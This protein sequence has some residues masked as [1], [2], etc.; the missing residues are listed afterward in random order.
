MNTYTFNGTEVVILYTDEVTNAQPIYTDGDKG[1]YRC[2]DV[3][4][5]IGLLTEEDDYSGYSGNCEIVCTEC[6]NPE[7]EQHLLCGFWSKEYA[8]Q[9]R[10]IRELC[11]LTDGHYGWTSERESMEG[12]ISS[13]AEDGE[14]SEEAAHRLR[15]DWEETV[16]A[17]SPSAADIAMKVPTF[18]E[19]LES[20]GVR[21]TDKLEAFARD[22]DFLLFRDPREA[23]AKVLFLPSMSAVKLSEA[24]GVPT[25]S[26]SRF[27]NGKDGLTYDNLCKVLN[28]LGI[29]LVY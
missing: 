22:N 17:Y 16:A 15:Q 10:I 14:I 12:S 2:E 6:V 28:A 18:D 5:A 11:T 19:L 13:E 3:P 21:V 20:A 1:L 25:S 24:S 4:E 7:N 8:D 29:R 9:D 26:I 23:I 27:I